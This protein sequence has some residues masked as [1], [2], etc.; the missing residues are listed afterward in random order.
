MRNQV[1]DSTT[2]KLYS[3]NLAEFVFCLSLLDS[4]DSEST[5]GVVDQ[6][7]VLASLVNRDDIHEPSRVGGV[8]S[9]FAIDFDQSLHHDSSRL[10]AIEG[11]LQTVSKE[12]N[13]REAVTSFLFPRQH[14]YRC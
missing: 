9:D 6:T 5:F 14:F 8:C 12:D 13:Q 10:A 3:L 1:W 2:T 11:I 4:V 7:K